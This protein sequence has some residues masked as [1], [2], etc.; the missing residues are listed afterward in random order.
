MDHGICLCMHVVGV[1]LGAF[2]DLGFR[3]EERVTT[4]NW[5]ESDKTGKRERILY[6]E[7]NKFQNSEW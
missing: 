6:I 4:Q 1:R 7:A 5:L 2:M 3:V